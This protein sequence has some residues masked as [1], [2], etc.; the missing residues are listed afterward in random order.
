MTPVTVLEP[1]GG[2]QSK[3]M[4]TQV[5]VATAVQKGGLSPAISSA[6]AHMR[7]VYRPAAAQSG[8]THAE[9]PPHVLV[10]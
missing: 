6:Y 9:P 8:P 5:G 7:A 3:S 2:G 10:E 1:P 4:L